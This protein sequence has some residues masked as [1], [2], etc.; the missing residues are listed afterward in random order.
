MTWGKVAKSLYGLI[1]FFSNK[2]SN[3]LQLKRLKWRLHEIISVKGL[4]QWLAHHKCYIN[5]LPI[6]LPPYSFISLYCVFLPYCSYWHYISQ[7][8]LE[9]Q[10]QW[11]R[12]WG[13]REIWL[14]RLQRLR[15]P[16]PG[17]AVCKLKTQENQWW[18]YS[19]NFSIWEPEEPSTNLSP[20]SKYQSASIPEKGKMNG[21]V[22]L[23]VWI[24]TS[25]PVSGLRGSTFALISLWIP[26]LISY[27][28]TLAGTPRNNA[29]PDSWVPK[30]QQR[31]P[32]ACIGLCK[33][34]K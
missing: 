3:G 27:R 13:S 26:T 20:N 25:F 16:Y 4:R 15:S 24:L 5:H 18:C 6:T 32:T 23:W 11:G 31:S 1:F 22:K 9:K 34:M 10:S 29:S 33:M 2:K 14:M 21:R 12:E 28:N 19:P 17:S 8:P 7:R 30:T